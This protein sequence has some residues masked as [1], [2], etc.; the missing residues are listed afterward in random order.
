MTKSGTKVF[1]QQNAIIP[2]QIN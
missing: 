2:V 1:Q